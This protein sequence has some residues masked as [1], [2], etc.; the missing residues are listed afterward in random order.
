MWGTWFP[1]RLRSWEKPLST[2]PEKGLEYI[3]ATS[4]TFGGPDGFFL[5][6]MLHNGKGSFRLPTA[7][8][9]VVNVYTSYDVDPEKD[10]K[11]LVG[12]CTKVFYAGTISFN[13]KP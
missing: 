4:N 7:G 5:S 6:A 13:V 8:Q 11:T 1:L 9:W 3:T 2:T 12:K 10:P